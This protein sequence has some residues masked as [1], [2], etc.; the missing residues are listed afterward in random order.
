MVLNQMSLKLQTRQ[1]DRKVGEMYNHVITL[2]LGT[3]T[4][5]RVLGLLKPCCFEYVCMQMKAVVK[6]MVKSLK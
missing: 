4:N 1:N 3:L 6:V 5:Y 2:F